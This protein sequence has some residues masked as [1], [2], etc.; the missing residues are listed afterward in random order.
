MDSACKQRTLLYLLIFAICAA[1]VCF[2]ARRSNV[3]R[4]GKFIH[5]KTVLTSCF[6]NG[7]YNHTDRLVIIVKHD[8]DNN[9]VK[10][11]RSVKCSFWV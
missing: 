10:K 9:F 6:D 1:S 2:G 3:R 4:S 7:N 8:T 11:T 5:R